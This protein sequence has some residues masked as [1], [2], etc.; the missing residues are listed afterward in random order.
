MKKKIN[1]PED[2]REDWKCLAE[3]EI[4]QLNE[5]IDTLELPEDTVLEIEKYINHYKER[6][7]KAIDNFEVTVKIALQNDE[8]FSD[9]L[10]EVKYDGLKVGDE[11]AVKDMLEYAGY[12][13]MKATSLAE[14]MK[15]EAFIEEMKANPYQLTLVA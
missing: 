4:M 11:D 9:M 12:F 8:L 5:D 10:F 3:D 7:N 1:K 6:L 14:Q 15:V 13:V 2:L